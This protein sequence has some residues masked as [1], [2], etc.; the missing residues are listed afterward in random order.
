MP[1]SGSS[2]AGPRDRHRLTGRD[3]WTYAVSQQS[4]E[5]T[6]L[7]DALAVAMTAA[8]LEVIGDPEML[9]VRAG[10]DAGAHRRAAYEALATELGVGRERLRLTLQGARWVTLP[11]IR[12]ALSSPLVG[13]V[14]ERRLAESLDLVTKVLHK[15]RKSGRGAGSRQSRGEGWVSQ[16]ATAR[17]KEPDMDEIAVIESRIRADVVTLDRML[18]VAVQ[19]G[20]T[21]PVGADWAAVRRALDVPRQPVNRPPGVGM[22]SRVRSAGVSSLAEMLRSHLRDGAVRQTYVLRAAIQAEHPQI[23]AE[24]IDAALARLF[25]RGEVERLDRGVYRASAAMKPPGQGG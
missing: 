10:E 24:Q 25:R 19:R 3:E 18:Q 2:N 5:P 8:L 21:L 20:R 14:L 23:T 7:P 11:E 4:V 17:R 6:D 9:S 15:D 22:A 12:A 16:E 1:R 13:P